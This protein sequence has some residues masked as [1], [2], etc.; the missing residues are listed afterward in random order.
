[1]GLKSWFA[2]VT[3]T[4][5]A[6]GEVLREGGHYPGTFKGSEAALRLKK[7]ASSDER[8]VGLAVIPETTV[9]RDSVHICL[10]NFPPATARRLGEEMIAFADEAE[11]A[12]KD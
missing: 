2:S 10:I 1:M 9:D 7:S 5:A 11:T 3:G 4:G 12:A 6:L 8:F